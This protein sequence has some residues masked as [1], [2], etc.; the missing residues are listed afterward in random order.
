MWVSVIEPVSW[1][2]T[3]FVFSCA[4]LHNLRPPCAAAAVAVDDDR[5]LRRDSSNVS[6]P[7]EIHWDL[8]FVDDLLLLLPQMQN[9]GRDVVD[10]PAFSVEFFVSL[11]LNQN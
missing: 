7:R 6:Y 11:A 3:S 2:V 5:P 1:N 9:M 8:G 10:M 4:F